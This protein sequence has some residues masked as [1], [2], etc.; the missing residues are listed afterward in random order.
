MPATSSDA[1]LTLAA[2]KAKM[3]LINT[4]VLCILPP[5]QSANTTHSRQISVAARFAALPQIMAW[6]NQG[7]EAGGLNT[8]QSKLIQLVAEEL[9]VNVIHHGYG[10]ECDATI[11]LALETHNNRATLTFS[12]HAAPFNLLQVKPLDASTE[13]I[14]GVGLNLVRN[15]ASEIRYQRL[16]DRNITMLDFAQIDP[17]GTP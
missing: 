1:A 13:R 12:D 16:D 11:E 4:L 9:F 17:A 8:D 3:K 10:S 7:A 5:H 6:I 15:L 14:G 2:K